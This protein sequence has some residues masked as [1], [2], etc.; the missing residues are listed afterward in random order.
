MYSR[1]PPPKK[2]AKT[3]AYA[4]TDFENLSG[5]LL[6]SEPGK[7]A[8]AECKLQ[9]SGCVSFASVNLSS[10]CE[11]QGQGDNPKDNA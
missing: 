8:T 11:K 7:V 5:G 6:V 9:E 3:T 2:H 4:S 1:K 10:P